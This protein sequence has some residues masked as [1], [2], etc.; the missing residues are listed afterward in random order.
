MPKGGREREEEKGRKIDKSRIKRD[1][2]RVRDYKTGRTR[3]R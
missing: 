3:K 1:S 2:K